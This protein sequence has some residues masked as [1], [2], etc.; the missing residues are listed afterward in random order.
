MP[1]AA[2]YEAGGLGRVAIVC[3]AGFLALGLVPMMAIIVPLWA[4]ELESSPAVIGLAIGARSLL[5]VLLSIHG[6]ALM[7]RLGAERVMCWMA[8]AGVVLSPLYVL[9]PTV[10][11]L[12][13]LQVLLGL[14]QALAWIGAQAKMLRMTAGDTRQ[15]GRFSFAATLG[16]FIAPVAAGFVW[17]MAGPPGA[18]ALV[19]L[20]NLA[21]LGTTLLLSSSTGEGSGRS[22]PAIVGWADLLPRFSDYVS[23]FRMMAVPAIAFIMAGTF[24]RISAIAVQGSFYPVHLENTGFDGASIG[25]LIGLSSMIGGP[26]ALLADPLARRLGSAV[27]LLLSI[28]VAVIS[29]AITPLLPG[30][31]ALTGAAI[32]F[33][34]AIGLG[35]PLILTVVARGTEGDRQG[36]SLGLRATANRLSAL[37]VPIIMGIVA[38]LL[39]IAA[40]FAVVGIV[41]LALTAAAALLVRRIPRE[42]PDRQRATTP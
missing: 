5:P 31:A 40:S 32:F 11:A 3:A 17:D 27:V 41:L 33:G 15:A 18:F 24:L 10:W 12:L 36:T 7:D 14:A 4:L 28:T 38:D 16:T 1:G 22:T 25:W 26:A 21:L 30:M 20:W 19:T 13:I 2:R 6:G 23:A 37:T 8:V 34:T 39:G 9:V 42:E 29:I 35:L